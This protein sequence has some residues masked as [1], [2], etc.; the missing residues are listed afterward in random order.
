MRVLQLGAVLT[1]SLA[2]ATGCGDSLAGDP[3]ALGTDVSA[4]TRWS[5]RELGPGWSP[6]LTFDSKGFPLVSVAQGV[7]DP[8]ND[9]AD[10]RPV[11]FSSDSGWRTG[12]GWTSVALAHVPGFRNGNTNSLAMNGGTTQIAYSSHQNGRHMPIHLHLATPGAMGWQVQV[13][14]DEGNIYQA[15]QRT[16]DEATWVAF[17]DPTRADR[18]AV[19]TNVSGTWE[20]HRVSIPAATLSSMDFAI[21]TSKEDKPVLGLATTSL[22]EGLRGEPWGLHFTTSFDGGE[23]WEDV[24]HID[25]SWAMIGPQLAYSGTDPMIAYTELEAKRAKFAYSADGGQT[26]QVET[27]GTFDVNPATG[28]AIDPRTGQPV[29]AIVARD[30]QTAEA[31]LYV[32]R[33]NLVGTWSLEI[34]DRASLSMNYGFAVNPRIAINDEGHT[35][36][37]WER[38]QD[39]DQRVRFAWDAP[40]GSVRP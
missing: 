28:L 8:T 34:V 39:R 19:A 4:L 15:V 33:R 37:A 20:T 10:V 35:A 3:E 6:S 25:D 30:L 23:T 29:V 38:Y 27:I 21:S 22:G 32:A 18:F 36:I 5:V 13:L 40:S 14:N 1:A 12:T 9:G 24:V 31:V 26:W 17:D 2:M 7:P 11:L 16:A